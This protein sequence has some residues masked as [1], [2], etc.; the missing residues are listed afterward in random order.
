MSETA[1]TTG[2]TTGQTGPGQRGPRP[3]TRSIGVI[4]GTLLTLTCMTPASSLFVIVPPLFGSL[5]TGTALTIALAG[6]LCVGIALC[7]GELG[8]LVPSAGGEY[9]MLGTLTGRFAGWLAFAVSLVVVMIIPPIMAIGVGAYLSP[10]VQVSGPVAGG[11]VLLLATVT[12]LLNLRANAWITGVFL[13][14]EVVAAA[15]VAVLGFGHANKPVS[16][17]LQPTAGADLVA[18]LAIIA[19]LAVALFVLQGFTTA[20]Y[21][22]EELDN[23]RRTVSR[24]VLATLAIGGLVVLVPVVAII[25]GAPDA[26]TL[27]AGDLSALVSGWSTPEVGAFISLCIAAAIVNACVVMVIQNSRVL[28]ASARDRAWPEPVNR[29]LG[30]V[31]RRFDA[32]WVATLVVG[33]PGAALCFVPVATL[34]GVTG[35]AVVA[36]YLSVSLAALAVRGRKH[37][38]RPAWRMPLWPAVPIAV[39]A[40]LIYV[41][42]VQSVADLLVVGVVLVA[43][44]LYWLLYLRPRADTRWI[45]SL[46]SDMGATEPGAGSVFP[47]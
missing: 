39:S 10:V 45:V 46:P 11:L 44:A 3:L 26:D 32:P 31:S 25:L 7:Y 34:N 36:L 8:T 37:R 16:V 23:P 6:L 4:G 38:H 17:L 40:V 41:L 13:V 19:G 28:Y 2:T 18:P 43:A 15:V 14:V 24:T 21:L 12:G 47:A 22:S 30:V 27:A 42:G 5:G 20:V 9:A 1:L 33:L 29:A 35:V